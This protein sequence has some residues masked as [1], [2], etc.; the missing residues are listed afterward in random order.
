MTE[1]RALRHVAPSVASVLIK[2]VAVNL[3][4]HWDSRVNST[5]MNNAHR[6]PTGLI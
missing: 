3:F 6:L 1:E 2:A 5:E 4:S